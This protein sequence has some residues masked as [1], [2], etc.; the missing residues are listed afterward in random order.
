MGDTACEVISD[1]ISPPQWG[2]ALYGLKL[3]VGA[4]EIQKGNFPK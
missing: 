4:S 1:F 2:F 3:P